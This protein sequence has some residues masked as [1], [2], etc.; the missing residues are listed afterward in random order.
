MLEGYSRWDSSQKLKGGDIVA[1]PNFQKDN[2]KGLTEIVLGAYTRDD[3]SM[4]S[5]ETDTNYVYIRG[6]DCQEDSVNPHDI[7]QVPPSTSTANLIK[8]LEYYDAN[9]NKCPDGAMSY[10]YD[11]PTKPPR[12]NL[13]KIMSI[14]SPSSG[15]SGTVPP[16]RAPVSYRKS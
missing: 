4:I 9:N 5:P 8:N 1:Y 14:A 11:L 6:E 7:M 16:L 15:P 12:P 13:P 10:A 2:S 3:T